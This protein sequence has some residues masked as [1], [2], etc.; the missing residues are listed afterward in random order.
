MK[1]IVYYCYSYFVLHK[2]STVTLWS[3]PSPSYQ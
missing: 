2:Q 1:K 3:L